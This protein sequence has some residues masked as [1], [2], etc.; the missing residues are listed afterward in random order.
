LGIAISGL[1]GSVLVSVIVVAQIRSAQVDRNPQNEKN[2]E[3]LAIIKDCTEPTG[4]CFKDAQRR[5]AKAVG[6]INRV[7]IIAAACASEPVEQ[8]VAQIADCVT[9]RLADPQ[10][11][12]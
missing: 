7:I 11:L 8:S 12:S 3:T 4:A 1:I 10:Q 6:D 2:D 5:T 9:R